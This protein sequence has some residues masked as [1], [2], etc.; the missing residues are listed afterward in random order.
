MADG[1]Q[2]FCGWVRTGEPAGPW[3]KLVESESPE[4]A[5]SLT[6]THS[7][8]RCRE[9]VVLPEGEEPDPRQA[10]RPGEWRGDQ[11]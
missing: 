7:Q 8:R 6:R 3:R 9:Y 2:R 4:W 10:P 11:E 5:E 1:K